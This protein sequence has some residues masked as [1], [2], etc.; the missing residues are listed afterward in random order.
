M[1]FDSHFKPCETVEE[2]NEV[3]DILR[4]RTPLE[5]RVFLKRACSRAVERLPTEAELGKRRA[6]VEAYKKEQ[7]QA[8]AR[9]ECRYLDVGL[10]SYTN[11]IHDLVAHAVADD[12]NVSLPRRW[13]SKHSVA[14][15]S[16]S[17]TS[18]P[19]D[20][21]QLVTDFKEMVREARRVLAECKPTPNLDGDPVNP[22]HLVK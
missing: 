20:A 22:Y 7:A 19:Q 5:S 21:R 10:R 3:Y 15:A 16:I 11:E 2:C 13:L 4:A 1:M 6:F 14:I 17:N 8:K 18:I 12:T 9:R